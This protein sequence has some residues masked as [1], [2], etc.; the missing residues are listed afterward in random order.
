MSGIRHPMLVTPRAPRYRQT[1]EH[2]SSGLAFGSAKWWE[3]K[4]GEGGEE[5]ECNLLTLQRIEERE[6]HEK[7]FSPDSRLIHLGAT[8]GWKRCTTT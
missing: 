2:G 4:Q 6:D 7:P 8:G 5:E 1:E 3:H